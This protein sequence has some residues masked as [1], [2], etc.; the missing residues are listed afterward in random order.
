[1]SSYSQQKISKVTMAH[2]QTMKETGEKIASITAY[3]YTKITLN[4]N[5]HDWLL[6]NIKSFIFQYY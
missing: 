1:M 6:L 3:D 4:N 5:F 2:L